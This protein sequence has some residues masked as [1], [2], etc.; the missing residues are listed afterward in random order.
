MNILKF[1]KLFRKD[2]AVKGYSRLTIENYVSQTK[3]FLNY[4]K[5]EKEP[6]YI[7]TDNIKDYLLQANCVNSQRHAHSA[8]KLFYTHVS[9]QVINQVKT[10]I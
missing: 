2:L 9:T 3:S 6:K 4:F 8:I 5:S 1:E 10:P 7:T